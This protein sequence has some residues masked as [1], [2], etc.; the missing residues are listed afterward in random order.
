TP[1]I[2]WASL[3]A[4]QRLVAVATENVRAFIEGRPQ[5]NVAL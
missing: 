1:H 3:E 2:A 5:N 4:R